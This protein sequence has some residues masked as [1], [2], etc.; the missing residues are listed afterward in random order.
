LPTA[1]GHFNFGFGLKI[2]IAFG[3]IGIT[4]KVRP[5]FAKGAQQYNNGSERH[6]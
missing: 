1:V 4:L 5:Q 3:R 6:G 2:S